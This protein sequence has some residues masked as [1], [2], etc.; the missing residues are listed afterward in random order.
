[1]GHVAE[2]TTRV[3]RGP[4]PKPGYSRFGGMR[5]NALLVFAP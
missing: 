4:N 3:P 1:M 5:G 2:A